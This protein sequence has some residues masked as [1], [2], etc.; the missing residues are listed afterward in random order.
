M[1]SALARVADAEVTIVR[2]GLE[3]P[4]RAEG[5][6]NVDVARDFLR[7]AQEMMP[8]LGP[9]LDTVHR[10]HVA[11]A[12]RRY[13][14]WGVP[15]TPQSTTEA[16]IGFADLVGFTALAQRRTATELDELVA[17]FEQ[18]VVVVLARPYARLVK[19]IGDEA[20]FA[21]GDAVEAVAVTRALL[22]AVEADPMLP[23]VRVGLAAGEV[24]A[25]EGDL[26]GPVVN[27]ASRLV[28][29]ASPGQ[30]VLDA[31]TARRLGDAV[32]VVA[33]GPRPVAG[34]EAPVEVFALTDE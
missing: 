11:V 3:A 23:S 29:V 26:F 4:L 18:V 2:A 5:A 33:L 30:V 25:R 27:L 10:H 9:A 31:E 14:L 21:V 32:P 17:R 12:G 7:T 20:M 16:V 6:G 8:L 19:L 22:A 24:L 15:P 1:G 13:A 28:G 34:F